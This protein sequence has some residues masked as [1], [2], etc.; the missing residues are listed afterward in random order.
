MK[1][2]T[3]NGRA[4]SVENIQYQCTWDCIYCREK[5]IGIGVLPVVGD[6]FFYPSFFSSK[7]SKQATI[8][9][10]CQSVQAHFGTVCSQ[11]VS[12]V[13]KT[14]QYHQALSSVEPYCSC[15][16]KRQPWQTNWFNILKPYLSGL[17]YVFLIL[18]ALSL[19]MYGF[20]FWLVCSLIIFLLLSYFIPSF[21]SFFQKLYVN[22]KMK[23]YKNTSFFPKITQINM[24]SSFSANK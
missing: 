4:Q 20:K 22:I 11:F 19:S 14:Q 6:S 12:T 3:R 21:F 17:Y 13:N 2:Y 8:Q 18:L 1:T 24:P 16:E 23:K 10:S 5:N 7:K 15:C 9:A